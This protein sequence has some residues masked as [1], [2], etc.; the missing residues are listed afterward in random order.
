MKSTV[1]VLCQIALLSLSESNVSCRCQMNTFQIVGM[2]FPPYVSLDCVSVLRCGSL[3]T[4]RWNFV[5]K[6]TVT[7]KAIPLICLKLHSSFN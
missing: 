5:L 2:K 4:R 3:V 6:K 1:P 7:L